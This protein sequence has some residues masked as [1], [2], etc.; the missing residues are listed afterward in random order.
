M[1]S[2]EYSLVGLARDPKVI[3]IIW[4]F[5][6][7]PLPCII[8]PTIFETMCKDWLSGGISNIQIENMV[9]FHF[10]KLNGLYRVTS[11]PWLADS[12]ICRFVHCSCVKRRPKSGILC[13]RSSV[14]LARLACSP[15]C[16][17]EHCTNTRRSSKAHHAL[18]PRHSQQYL[19]LKNKFSSMARPL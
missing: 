12:E 8:C 7:I 9:N 2:A 19:W 10:R 15:L 17:R 4:H 1:L 11:N 3:E 14:C 13:V 16:K 6:V 5:K 18:F